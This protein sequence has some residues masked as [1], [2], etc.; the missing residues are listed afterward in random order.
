VVLVAAA[1]EVTEVQVP[2]GGL[3][4]VAVEVA[5]V[6]DRLLGVTVEPAL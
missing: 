2:Q 4:L 5:V 6:L 3:T 1:M